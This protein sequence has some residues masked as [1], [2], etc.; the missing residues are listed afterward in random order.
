MNNPIVGVIL[1]SILV[2]L[3]CVV[4]TADFGAPRAINCELAEFH[5]DL[6]K[7]REF[8]RKMRGSK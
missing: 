7:Y 6:V 8:C 1:L 4:A 2:V 3:A 5:P